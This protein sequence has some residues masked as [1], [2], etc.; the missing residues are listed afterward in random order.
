MDANIGEGLVPIADGQI[1]LEDAHSDVVTETSQ[2][3]VMAM[4]RRVG[5][6]GDRSEGVGGLGNKNI[7]SDPKGKG[8]KPNPEGSARPVDP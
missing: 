1:T 6:H 3:M 8:K 5:G 4:M 7:P 2:M